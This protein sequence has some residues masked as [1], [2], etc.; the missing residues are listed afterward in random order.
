[1]KILTDKLKVLYLKLMFV[2]NFC[3]VY[4]QNTCKK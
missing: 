3:N 4:S 1:M 2:L